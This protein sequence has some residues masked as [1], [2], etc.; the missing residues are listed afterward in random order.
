[1]AG[2]LSPI[3]RW[4]L[5]KDGVAAPGALLY[6]YLSGTSTPQAVYNNAD[7]SDAHAHTNPVVADSDGVL[8][9]LY[10]KPLAYRY[11]VTDADGAT[12][13]PAQDDVYD[14]AQVDG[15]TDVAGVAG[16]ALA[17]GDAVYLASGAGGTT[18]GR[19]YKTDADA[20][21]SSS[22]AP[23]V[24]MTSAAIALGASGT[25]RLMGRQTGLSGLVAGSNYYVSA[26][27]GAITATVP[28]NGRFVGQADSA[29]TLVVG[30]APAASLPTAALPVGSICQIVTATYSTETSS[31]SNVYA[32]T[33]LTATITPSSASNKILVIV[34]VNGVG[35]VTN[36]TSP[37]LKLLRG[38]TQ[39]ALASWASLGAAAPQSLG[40]AGWTIYDA[41]AATTATTYK[42]QFASSANAAAVYVQL[43][44]STS[45][46]T[47]MEIKQ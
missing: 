10:L 24:G 35:Y 33:G 7:L 11:L 18:A 42:V 3:T 6:T 9:V 19:W 31:T 25:I 44:S 23:L 20:I 32:D 43:S 27:A 28:N 41:P 4:Q 16:E 47:L 1:M 46:I 45:T 2:A 29:T 21:A 14:F 34:N 39:L 38:V 12:I 40:A 37:Q 5:T 22:G 30:A 13:Y 15:S 26:T 36:V 17:A 8:P